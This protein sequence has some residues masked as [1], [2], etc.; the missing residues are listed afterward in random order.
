M[1]QKEKV[2]VEKLNAELDKVTKQRIMMQ[3]KL[4]EI[5]EA[6]EKKKR[7][8]IYREPANNTISTSTSS[9]TRSSSIK[10]PNTSFS[11]SPRTHNQVNLR[12]NARATK[13]DFF[14]SSSVRR[15][16]LIT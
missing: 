11:I 12:V 8:Q 6:N 15:Y 13:S 3:N 16:E 14:S 4:R 2:E 9:E 7:S 1:F 5:Y 10:T